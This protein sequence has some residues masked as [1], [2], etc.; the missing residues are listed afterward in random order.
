MIPSINLSE[1]VY[2]LPEEKI[3]ER[4]LEKR[5]LSKLLI[6]KDASIAE[7]TFKNIAQFLP[8]KSLIIF[9]DTKVVPARLYFTKSTGA[10]IE[11]FCL[12]QLEYNP[13]KRFSVW[14]CMVGNAKKWKEGFLTANTEVNGIKTELKASIEAKNH[15]DFTIKFEW[16]KGNNFY[17]ILETFGKIPLPPYIKRE[18]DES[19][20]VRYQTVYAKF[21]GSVAAPTA[22]LHFTDEVIQSFENKNIKQAFVTLHVSA[23]TFRPISSSEITN[24]EMH[25]E[26][27]VIT[28]NLI[29]QL[30]SNI[31]KVIC[32]GT[33]SVRVIESLHWIGIALKNKAENPFYVSQWQPYNTSEKISLIDNLKQILNYFETS[34]NTSIEGATSIIIIPG[35]EFKICKGI[36]TNFHQ[37]ESTLILLVAA[38]VGNDWRKIYDFALNNQFR[39]LSYGDSS[40]LLPYKF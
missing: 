6:Y 17:D 36:I 29:E 32:V 27:F 19:D 33:T 4:P 18:A 39:F 38:F 22:G 21:Q 8:E 11:I 35:Y 30:L 16:D 37:P 2:S 3:A 28:K 34:Q 7:N 15:S 10:L 23:G 5:D 31:E 25:A 40:L 9:N 24:H 12:D 1:Y 26:R 14:K 13:E 20:T